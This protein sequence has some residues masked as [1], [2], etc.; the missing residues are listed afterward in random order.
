[1]IIALCQNVKVMFLNKF[2]EMRAAVQDLYFFL[3]KAPAL[4]PVDEACV[5]AQGAFGGNCQIVFGKSVGDE[6]LL[7]LLCDPGSFRAHKIGSSGILVP[8]FSQS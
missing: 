2:L 3:L 5:A 7:F 4:A 8:L 1:M 6:Q